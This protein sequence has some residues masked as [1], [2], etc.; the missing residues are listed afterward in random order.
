[1]VSSLF[2]VYNC[3]QTHCPFRSFLTRY[4]AVYIRY[5]ISMLPKIQTKEQPSQTPFNYLPQ[6]SLP[7]LRLLPWGLPPPFSYISL[8]SISIANGQ[9]PLFFGLFVST[10][11]RALCLSGRDLSGSRCEYDVMTIMSSVIIRPASGMM[12]A[13]RYSKPVRSMAKGVETLRL[14]APFS[15]VQD[16]YVRKETRSFL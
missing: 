16:G 13:M 4:Q 15:I 12:R 6:T 7:R 3:V 10:G 8:P 5:Y 11:L 14:G 9:P 1:M 2:A